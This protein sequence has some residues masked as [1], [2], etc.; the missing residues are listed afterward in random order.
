MTMRTAL[1]CGRAQGL[2]NAALHC[3]I[4]PWLHGQAHDA[5]GDC[6][7]DGQCGAWIGHRR[8]AVERSGVVHCRGDAG[9]FEGFL[10]LGAGVVALNGRPDW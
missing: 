9:G 7:A 6:V 5:L 1:H 10:Q 3:W 4:Q 8:L 2:D